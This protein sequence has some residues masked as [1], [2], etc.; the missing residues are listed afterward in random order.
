MFFILNEYPMFSVLGDA[1]RPPY[2]VTGR[3]LIWVAALVGCVACKRKFDKEESDTGARDED[4]KRLWVV[5]RT[6]GSVSCSMARVGGSTSTRTHRCPF[7]CLLEKTAE[8]VVDGKTVVTLTYTGVDGDGI[9]TPL[10]AVDWSPT[11]SLASRSG[12][13]T[14]PANRLCTR[15][16]RRPSRW[17]RGDARGRVCG[18]HY[19]GITYTG[20][21]IGM[22]DCPNNWAP[23]TRGSVPDQA[24]Q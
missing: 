10:Y 1:T 15:R 3:A 5:L 11:L 14:S 4:S 19:G 22:E 2:R 20:Q 24:H 9:E 21:F 18:H 12:G 23:G 8:A 16:T 17:R 7:S 6:S 13:P